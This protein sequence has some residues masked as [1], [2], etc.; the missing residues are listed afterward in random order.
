MIFSPLSLF[1]G[2]FVTILAFCFSLGGTYFTWHWCNAAIREK[3]ALLLH[4]KTSYFMSEIDT[5]YQVY[6]NLLQGMRG[7]FS[8]SVQVDREEF[9]A[10]LESF[11]SSVL[12]PNHLRA[13]YNERAPAEEASQSEPF[14][15]SNFPLRYAFPPDNDQPSSGYG[16]P[17]LIGESIIRA[18]WEG[19]TPVAE[20][21][22][23]P[24]AAPGTGS[25]HGYRLS[26]PVY[27]KGSDLAE[28]AQR[29]EA[30]QG[31]VSLIFTLED[32]FKNT[33]RTEFFSNE[34][35]FELYDITDPARPEKLYSWPTAHALPRLGPLNLKTSPLDLGD[36]R[37]IFHFY[38]SRQF[39]LTAVECLLPLFAL[40]AGGFITMLVS[41]MIFF[42]VKSF[43]Q[44]LLL[45]QG[46]SK[47]LDDSR[48]HL[49]LAI[50]AAGV[51]MW[52][53]DILKDE[54]TVDENTRRQYGKTL[55]G[56]IGLTDF[57]NSLHPGDRDRIHRE[58]L[59]CIESDADYETSY[60]I[61]RSDG[62][63]R[64]QA[65]HGRVYRNEDG[66]A[67]RM[68]GAAWDISGLK[69]AEE[70]SRR[71]E[72]NYRNMIEN[73]GDGVLIVSLQD[74]HI[75]FA[76]HAA[77]GLFG[78]TP[79]SLLG[80]QFG[81]PV[82]SGKAS[83]INVM[84]SD[85][86]RRV[87]ELRATKSE[88]EEKPAML[89]FLRDVTDRKE[90]EAQVIQSQKMD[91][92]GQLTGGIA[93]DFNNLLTVINGYSEVQLLS[94]KNANNPARPALEEILKAGKKA[95][96]LTSQLLAFSRRQILHPR[97]VDMNS[98]ITDLDKMLR[99]L[100]TENIELRTVL[101]PDLLKVMVDRGQFEQVL[102]NLVINSRDAMPSGGVL[103]IETFNQHC[104]RS[105]AERYLDFK[106]GD[107]VVLTVTDT[108][109]GMNEETKK[110]IFEPFFT[111]KEQGKGTGLGLSTVY[112]IV[113][114]ANGHITV[115]SEPGMG[116]SFKVYIPSAQSAAEE[117]KPEAFDAEENL[118][119]TE[120]ILVVEDEPQVR[121][122]TVEVLQCRGYAV[123]E[124]SNG[125]EGAALAEKES[126]REISLIITDAI[127]PRLSGMEM[128]A[129]IRP[130]RP[131][132]KV[133]FMSGYTNDNP[134]MEKELSSGQSDFL[135]KPFSGTELAKQV[136]QIL[137]RDKSS[138]S[139]EKK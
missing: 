86:K 16:A 27:S 112:G 73:S 74:G 56:R 59:A 32:L 107:Y 77:A 10:Y 51:G 61:I 25:A 66:K 34:I 43:Q 55:S 109:C 121:A 118:R 9:T 17:P 54:V 64:V 106:P 45:T 128:V 46:I 41:V 22:P 5:R 65:A 60:R 91:A 3:S 67:V 97:I 44:N 124:A 79:D 96:A 117:S 30:L 36:R 82:I 42:L 92:V 139:S 62:A 103:T 133:L 76:N 13:F 93:H 35:Y 11:S 136:R 100:I 119:G 20:A 137:N 38:A 29:T 19:Q 21:T 129:R 7:L 33:R 87:V 12:F 24:D 94:I 53:W 15:V 8:A 47:E 130:R 49:N 58:I 72:I 4:E 63:V 125:E 113:K 89:V 39:G 83:L 84:P 131:G 57:V 105:Y 2:Q 122:L 6:A 135:H 40:A 85:Q 71:S 80:T 23:I 126:H 111:T 104:G 90:L 81:F 102:M 26:V 134:A 78:K 14:A 116:A 120:T 95:A 123:L 127:M 69:K 88:W 98:L 37:W 99:R 31:F 132:I 138:K 18:A 114:Q 52:D 50:Q 115:S 108:G 48:E 68:T 28:T 70:A 75:L 101:A 1:R 110:R